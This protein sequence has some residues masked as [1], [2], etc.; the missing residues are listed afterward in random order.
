MANSFLTSYRQDLSSLGI[1]DNRPDWMVM[2]DDLIPLAK[3][4]PDLLK[5]YPDFAQE[6]GDTREANAP[7][8][9]G[10]FGQSLKS[11]TQ[12]LMSDLDAATALGARG[13]GL[14]KISQHYTGRAKEL[15]DLAAESAPTIPTVEDIGPGRT[16][17]G[18]AFSKDTA[19]YLAAKAGGAVPS[20]AEIAGL[21]VA[22]AA[23]GTAAEPGVG[24]LAGA[25]EGAIEGV[26]GRG[27]IRSAI[28][29]LVEK[30]ATGGEAFITAQLAAG[31]KNRGVAIARM[32]KDKPDIYAPW[33]ANGRK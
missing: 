30:D 31:A 29:A 20:L 10:E 32:A 8:L 12:S 9:A 18:R 28:K 3:Q 2:R 7:S 17:L 25:G 4:N 14:D 16:G 5:Q 21:S 13:L 26:L 33:N 6:Y 15:Q 24:T 1:E 19:R 27:V 11:G 23:L 22:G